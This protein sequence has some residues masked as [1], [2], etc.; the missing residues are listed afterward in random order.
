MQDYQQQLDM[1]AEKRKHMDQTCTP[2]PP[3]PQPSS[4]SGASASAYQHANNAQ[5]GANPF[6]RGELQQQQ[7]QPSDTTNI[8]ASSSNAV[9]V[10]RRIERM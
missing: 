6:K 2:P 10:D 7:Q 8:F 4:A 1:Y 9:R 5:H 3:Q